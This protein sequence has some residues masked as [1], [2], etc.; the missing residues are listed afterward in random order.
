M[1]NTVLPRDN[2]LQQAI[3]G[4]MSEDRQAKFQ[5]EQNDLTRAQQQAQADADLAEKRRIN[6]SGI[7]TNKSAI[8]ANT[9]TAENQRVAAATAWIENVYVPAHK[10][11]TQLQQKGTSPEEIAAAADRVNASLEKGISLFGEGTFIPVLRAIAE[12][13]G[14]I[15]RTAATDAPADQANRRDINAYN[16]PDPTKRP[17]AGLQ[18]TMQSIQGVAPTQ[19]ASTDVERG[20]LGD[21]GRKQAIGV[22]ANTIP[23]A[24]RLESERGATERARIQETGANRRAEIAASAAGG[25]GGGGATA[26]QAGRR[27]E[28]AMD[29]VSNALTS[30]DD[31]IGDKTGGRTSLTG[32]RFFNPS[33]WLASEKGKPAEGTDAYDALSS[34]ENI[35]NSLTA[36]SFDMMRG[37]GAMSEMEVKIIMS[38]ITR[39]RTGMSDA[40]YLAELNTLRPLVAKMQKNIASR[41]A[42]RAAFGTGAG[43]VNEGSD[44]M[45]SL[46]SMPGYDAS[47]GIITLPN[48]K[49]A[50][51]LP[52]GM[53]DTLD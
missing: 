21:A 9:A 5:S 39:L 49:R 25:A 53:V 52:N 15:L 20:A 33:Y 22:A 8:T 3:M 26:A 35:V 34:H 43:G 42:S 2:S 10:T 48:G 23:S 36:T 50:Q 1:G 6:D 14:E 46:T 16:D 11:L 30:L 27:D 19:A 28:V 37:L 4:M 18:A 51:V 24:D 38:A 40:K 32:Q 47:T 13:R 29:L 45:E 7:E 12:S 44:M 17:L 31:L 41:V